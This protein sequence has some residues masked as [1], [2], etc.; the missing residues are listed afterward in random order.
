M[1]KLTRNLRY[2]WPLHLVY[3]L[4][5]WLPDNVKVLQ[6]RGAWMRPFLGSCGRG[7]EVGRNV[8]FHD[9]AKVHLGED[10]YISYGCILLAN[11]HIWIDDEVMF[12]PYCVMVSGNHTRVAHSYRYGAPDLAPIR[13]GKGSWLGAHVVVTAG[14]TIGN[15]ALIA[16]GAVVTGE[17]PG[18]T[19]AGGL[20]ARVLK[21]LPE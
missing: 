1:N 13:I 19:M 15:G 2:D 10:V 9:P 6:W 20:P 11:E 14:S 12:G 3:L 8:T 7:L 4:T 17:I 5:N 21:P 16:A 18:D